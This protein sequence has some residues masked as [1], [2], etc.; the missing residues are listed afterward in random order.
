MR[1]AIHKKKGGFTDRWQIHCESQGVPFKWVDCYRSDIIAQLADCDALMWHYDYWAPR[2]I[3][4][5]KQII[6]ALAHSGMTVFPDPRTMWHYDDK[7]AQKYLLEGIGAPLVPSHVFYEEKAA[8]AWIKSAHYPLVFK[9]RG[10]TGSQNVRLVKNR[11]EAACIVKKSFSTGFSLYPRW[12]NL[13]ERVRKYREGKAASWDVAKGIARLLVPP[14]YARISGRQRGCVYFQDFIPGNGYDIR[15][16][17]IGDKAFAIK[18]MVRS[19]DF[20]ASGSGNIVYDKGELPVDTVT[21]A[22][23]I[24]RKLRTQCTAMDFLYDQGQ[25]KVIEISYGF[26]PAGYD[27]CPGYWDADLTWHEGSFDPYGWMV[28]LVVD[29]ANRRKSDQND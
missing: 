22:F 25:P 27:A 13:K 23:T 20:R 28:D 11:R 16:V 14:V 24:H 12:A 4:C 29:A 10:G 5:A 6:F 8:L 2:D 3:V 15:V 19:D 26:V 17:V 21:L 9:L 1:I 18:R 7:V